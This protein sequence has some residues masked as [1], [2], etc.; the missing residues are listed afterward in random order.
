[1]IIKRRAKISFIG[2]DR[3]R[4][5]THCKQKEFDLSNING[6]YL[7]LESLKLCC[8][9]EGHFMLTVNSGDG[10]LEDPYSIV[11]FK[12]NYDRGRREMMSPMM[13]AKGLREHTYETSVWDGK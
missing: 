3:I 6:K 1:M 7:D 12:M 2:L 5:I 9:H 4:I 10:S 11:V 13:N 8:S